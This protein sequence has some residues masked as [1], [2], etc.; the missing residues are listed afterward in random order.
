MLKKI[1]S[2]LKYPFLLGLALFMLWLAFRGISPDKN[3]INFQ[4][5]I[6]GLKNADV[7]W[8]MVSVMGGVGALFSRAYRWKLLMEPLGHKVSLYHSFVSLSTGYLFNLALPRAG[9]ITRCTMIARTTNIPFNGAFGTVITER[10]LDV[11]CLLM[12]I[13]SAY[14]L[15]FSLINDYFYKEVFSPILN[16][17]SGNTF[18]FLLLIV[19]IAALVAGII[20]YFRKQLQQSSLFMKISGFFN[21]L[22]KGV[23][24]ITKSNKP[25]SL[26]VSTIVIWISYYIMTYAICFCFG[27]TS[28]LGFV[29]GLVLLTV[30]GIGMSA[31]VQGGIG[32]FHLLVSGVL[33][34]YGIAKEDGLLYAILLHGSQTVFTLL[35]GGISFLL[36]LFGKKQEN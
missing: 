18:L 27:A 34:L 29:A 35:F 13:F 17:F 28:H 9:E 14:F 8:L 23:W 7:F 31:P 6:D 10:I 11:V 1:L 19:V 36:I 5:T 16:K 32:A 4:K 12:L 3:E 33:L 30:G 2:V 24:S 20:Y 15:E 21:G 26:V 22:V 25:V